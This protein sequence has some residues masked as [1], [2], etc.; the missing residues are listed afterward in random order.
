MAIFFTHRVAL[1]NH[2]F[3]SHGAMVQLSK[4]RRFDAAELQYVSD[5]MDEPLSNLE[6]GDEDTDTENSD[7]TGRL[8]Y[9]NRGPGIRLGDNVFDQ[10]FLP[11]KHHVG[12]VYA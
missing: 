5:T 1:F 6:S 12:S 8:D 3:A 2:Y 9:G 11:R 7:L 4:Q 10:N